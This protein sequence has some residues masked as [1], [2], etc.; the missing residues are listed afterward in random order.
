MTLWRRWSERTRSTVLVALVLVVGVFAEWRLCGLAEPSAW[1]PDF[2]VGVV[3][4]LVGAVLRVRDDRRVGSLLVAAGIAWFAGN[5]A[6]EATAWVA[7]SAE[8]LRL[9]HRAILFQAMITFPLPRL[10]DRVE[11]VVV[12]VAYAGVL[13]LGVARYEWWTI[14]WA[15]GMLVLCAGLIRRRTALLRSAGF[16]VLSVMAVFSA[17]L[18]LVAVML[19]SLGAAPAPRIAVVTY[20]AGLVLTALYLAIRVSEWRRRAVKVADAV[21]ELTLGPASNVRDLLSHALRDSSVEISFAVS[22]GSATWWVDEVGRSVESL[23]AA[24]RSVVPI[25]VDGRRVAEVA[26]AVDFQGLPALLAAVESATRLAADHARLRSGLRREVDVLAASRLRL[27]TAADDQRAGLAEQLERE[28]GSSLAQIRSVLAGIAPGDQAV[29]EAAERCGARLQSLEGDLGSLAAGLG[30][31][32]LTGGGLRQALEQLAGDGSVAVTLVVDGAVDEVSLGTARTIYFV[33]SEA[34]T[35]ASK[36]SGAMCV[37]VALRSTAAC[38]TLDIVDD[39]CG[40]A[41]LSTGS[42]LQNMADRVDAL[43]GIFDL[44]SPLG[45]GTRLTVELPG[46]PTRGG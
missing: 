17:V 21:V 4:A 41:H 11:R 20:Q 36:Y 10:R 45:A 18:I 9:I 43:G 31:A 39:G 22:D 25:L 26:S 35:N 2:M 27:L 37:R 38:M 14:A 7:W 29:D 12:V 6:G 23:S 34:I 44:N 15:I 16:Q 46:Q 40:G 8:H 32:A 33:C 19:L 28:A 30:P 24:G 13:V 5:F 1:L 3:V 42:G